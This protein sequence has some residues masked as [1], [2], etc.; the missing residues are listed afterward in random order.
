MFPY[1]LPP[2]STRRIMG[3]TI[4]VWRRGRGGYGKP[5]C[6]GVAGEALVGTLLPHVADSGETEPGWA[7]WP[8]LCPATSRVPSKGGQ[9]SPEAQP[10]SMKG[11]R[12][13]QGEEEDENRRHSRTPVCHQA[14]VL[15]PA[16]AKS[17]CQKLASPIKRL[18]PLTLALSSWLSSQT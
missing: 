5:G 15:W 11:S 12:G 8:L 17:S 3:P 1:P 4:C 6:T 13:W 16:C 2:Q 10:E 18:P 7:Q 14:W 9:D